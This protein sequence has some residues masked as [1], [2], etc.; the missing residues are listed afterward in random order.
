MNELKLDLPTY[1]GRYYC[2][3]VERGELPE[4]GDPHV[5][6]LVRAAMGVRVILGT[7]DA[8]D[9]DKPDILIERQPNGWVIFL[10][11]FGAG[12]PVGYVCFH[13]DG[14]SFLI[15]EYSYASACEIEVLD[16][17]DPIPGFDG[18]PVINRDSDA[19]RSVVIYERITANESFDA[20]QSDGEK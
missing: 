3:A 4:H 18:P 9:L 17:D 14:R 10:H 13:D 20:I 5:P 7:H 6:V 1:N 19:D 2:R 12:D 15:K 11:P 8:E 16:P